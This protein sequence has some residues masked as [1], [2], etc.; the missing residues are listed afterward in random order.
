M[1]YLLV[2]FQFQSHQIFHV[3]VLAGAF[4]H[5]HGISEIANYRLTLGDCLESE[6]SWNIQSWFECYLQIALSSPPPSTHTHPCTCMP[7]LIVL[8]ATHPLALYQW[9]V[10]VIRTEPLSKVHVLV[11]ASHEEWVYLMMSVMV[12]MAK[13]MA[14]SCSQ[15]IKFSKNL[16]LWFLETELRMRRNIV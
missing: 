11:S 7:C 1:K 3:F 16:N 5:Y 9:F 4:V 15:L 2:L 12:S 14:F 10:L 13:T 8:M 6:L